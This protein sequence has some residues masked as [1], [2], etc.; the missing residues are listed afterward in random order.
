MPGVSDLFTAARRGDV[1]TLNRLLSEGADPNARDANGDTPLMLAAAGGHEPVVRHLLKYGA[2]V[3]AVPVPEHATPLRIA[4]RDGNA[5][6]VRVLLAHGAD[7]NIVAPPRRRTE[8]EKAEWRQFREEMREWRRKSREEMATRYAS[9]PAEKKAEIDEIWRDQ[10]SDDEDEAFTPVDKTPG[11]LR[12]LANAISSQNIETLQVLLEAGF[13]PDPLPGEDNRST[14]LT[15]ISLAVSFGTDEMVRLL[16]KHGANPTRALFGAVMQ[17]RHEA[18]RMLLEA[19]ADP[20]YE[21]DGI[22]PLSLAHFNGDREMAELL[23]KY[24]A[25]S[26]PHM[27]FA[28]Q[29]RAPEV[30]EIIERTEGTDWLRDVRN[31]NLNAV[32]VR[33]SQG[34]PIEARDAQRNKTALMIAVDE[35]NVE[36]ARLLL[37]HGADPNATTE[38]GHRPLLRAVY[39]GNVELASLLIERGAEVAV[40]DAWGGTPIAAAARQGSDAMVERLTAAGAR[41]GI[42]EAALLGRADDVR[43][44]LADGT[45]VDFA[46]ESG[47]TALFGA[48]HR[49][50]ISLAD[51]LLNRGANVAARDRLGKT[52][53][54]VATISL[55]EEMV[56]FLLD[57]GA[58]INATTDTDKSALSLAVMG[59]RDSLVRLLLE[60]GAS[61]TQKQSGF[62]GS[63]SLLSD[64]LF[65]LEFSKDS[66]WTVVHTLLDAGDDVN[67]PGFTGKW[68]LAWAI[69]LGAPVEIIRLLM[70]K[71]ANINPEPEPGMFRS[72]RPITPLMAAAEAGRLD[73]VE[74]LLDAGADPNGGDHPI[75][76][77]KRAEQNGHA[78]IAD[79]LRA[80]GADEDA[81]RERLGYTEEMEKMFGADGMPVGVPIFDFSAMLKQVNEQ[82]RE[83]RQKWMQTDEEMEA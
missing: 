68:P 59:N 50:D 46:N 7:P 52:P 32:R 63:D 83:Q 44:F 45:P 24:G 47:M 11:H 67:R 51:E 55:Q 3:N 1:D 23:L 2:D 19:G 43:R 29:E 76:A 10:E 75:S 62:S 69:E 71:G 80:R 17:R 14:S 56:R 73:M 70:E 6:I 16:L 53:L 18:A 77:L 5:G 4:V 8:Q 64:A 78:E 72:E 79:R 49:G 27:V 39:R 34:V 41:V 9:L 22:K 38:Y 20:N 25:S 58:P 74:L 15:P 48:A 57:R 13:A 26:D 36:M 35:G 37:D 40:E 30:A 28:C 33:L 66:D 60:H 61:L 21:G 81:R 54:I 42:V 82:R 12:L 31:G 65:R